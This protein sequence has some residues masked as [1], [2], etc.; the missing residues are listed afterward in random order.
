MA[1]VASPS[2][3]LYPLPF[4]HFSDLRCCIKPALTGGAFLFR[5][6]T[7]RLPFLENGVL[8]GFP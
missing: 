1:E 7:G 3:S 5:D 4:E 6:Q 2:R 8:R